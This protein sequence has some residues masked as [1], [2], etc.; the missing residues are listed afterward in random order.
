MDRMTVTF[1]TTNQHKYQE[2][3][4]ILAEFPIKLV[5]LNRAYEEN[6][7]ASLQHIAS[8]AAKKLATELDQPIILEDTGLFFDAY[9]NFPGA[10]PKFVFQTLGYEG[11]LKLLN[12]SPRGAYFKTV[13]GF[14]E[15]RGEP[16]LFE[17]K[18]AGTITPEVHSLDKDAMPYDR[19]FMPVGKQ[20]TI[21]DMSLSEKNTFSQ[22]AQAFRAFGE[23]IKNRA[24]RP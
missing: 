23:Y 4:D 17:G 2:V 15:P 7:D 14:C 13:A 24:S 16:T 18:M 22:R 19:I 11:I 3:S 8:S 1:V 12:G 10:L 21:S 5:H 6:H 9:P 20:V